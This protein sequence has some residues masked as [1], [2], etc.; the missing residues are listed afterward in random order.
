[1]RNNKINYL[2][3]G[4]FVIAMMAGL[5]AALALLTG[6]TGATDEYYTVY[7]IGRAHV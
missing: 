5:A 4:G 1:M 7:E 3:V 6:R 2:V